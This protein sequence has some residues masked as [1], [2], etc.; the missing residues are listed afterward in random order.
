LVAPDLILFNGRIYP[1]VN[2]KRPCQALAVWRGRVTDIGSNHEILSLGGVRSK[3]RD[4]HGHVVLPGFTDSHIHLLNYGMM[5]R[6]LDLSRTTSIEDIKTRVGRMSSSKGSEDW[7]LGRGWDDE[8]LIDHRY[9]NKDDLDTVT[10]NPVFLRRVCGHVAVAN[11]SVLSKAGIT[12]DTT[13]PDGG[14]IVRK[15]N[16][17]PT[18]VLKERAIELVERIVPRSAVESRKA[19]TNASRRLARLGI[20]SLHCVVGDTGELVVLRSL[21]EEGKILQSIYAIVP[22]IAFDQ[23]VEAGMTTEK[24][25]QGFRI[26]GVKL[27]LDGSLGA[28][29]AALTRPYS[30]SPESKGML[31]MG[32]SE[33]EEIAS[34]AKQS[35]FQLCMHAIGDRAVELAISVLEASFSP[36]LCKRMRHRIEHSSLTSKHSLRKMRRL[37][38]IASVQP[39][40]I[41]SDSWAKARLGSDRLKDLYPLASMTREKLVVTAGSDCPVENPST[42]GG[43]WSAV[44][45][46]GLDPSEALTVEQALVDYTRNPAYASFSENDR[47]SLEPGKVADMVIVDKNPFECNQ[48]DLR[49]IRVLETIIDGR[50]VS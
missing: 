4:L 21:R 15:I 35:G 13:D 8:K 36:R 32:R 39:R 24:G 37:G 12:R 27:F 38:I 29:T 31:T 26:G 20:T 16:G 34:K 50:T 19:L 45:R 18:G 25:D 11:S 30:D 44:T 48:K 40:F 22:L 1:D 42:L 23:L 49:R 5:L 41:Y 7:I 3:R 47:G 2:P 17:E 9:P 6:T 10:T 28:R 14:L 46:P 33:L 43:I